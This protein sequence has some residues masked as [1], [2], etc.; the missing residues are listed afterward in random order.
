MA[1]LHLVVRAGPG[2]SHVLGLFGP[3]L[4]AL[5]ITALTEGREGLRDLFGHMGRWRVGLRWYVA[6]LSPLAFMG[7]AMLGQGWMGGRWPTLADFGRFNGFP[8]AGPIGLW[9]LLVLVSYGEET[10]WRGYALEQL[11][12]TRGPLAAS[13]IIAVF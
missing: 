3:M 7:I 13:L 12:P 11:Q 1:L 10:G 9:A 5:L 4:A 8:D 2:P 6:A